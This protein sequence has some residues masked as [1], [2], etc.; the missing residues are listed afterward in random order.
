MKQILDFNNNEARDFFL[1]DESYFNFDLPKYFVFENLLKKL[2][3]K[4][5]N[6]DIP[7]L[8]SK[9]INTN[10]GE[11]EWVNDNHSYVN[12]G[13]IIA[14]IYFGLGNVKKITAPKNG[15][16][17]RKSK[18]NSIV[19]KGKLIAKVGGEKVYF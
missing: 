2:S 14:Q 15:K 11:L 6:K 19:R 10:K 12:Q 5:G 13:T 9:K 1:K 18:D 4:F 3:D 7:R 8:E 17:Y 16:I